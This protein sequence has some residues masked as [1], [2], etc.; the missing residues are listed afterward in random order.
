[1]KIPTAE[2]S[3]VGRMGDDERVNLSFLL[4]EVTRLLRAAFDQ[5]M[6]RLDLTR[7]QWHA[8]IY[9]LRLKAASQTQLA[10]ALE[11]ARPSVGTL[12]DQLE[13]SGYVT[14]EADTQDRRIWRVVPTEFALA[15]SEEIARLAESVA[16]N[17][18]GGLSQEQIEAASSVIQVIRQ[19]LAS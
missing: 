9:V 6:K 2:N 18:F 3:F 11:V 7:S 4:A 15:R 5:E 8:L 13:K 17:A 12:I 14:R 1:M 16:N 10:E 19:N